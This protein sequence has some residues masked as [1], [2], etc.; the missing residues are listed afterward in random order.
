MDERA[1]QLTKL[2]DE[3]AARLAETALETEYVARLVDYLADEHGLEVPTEDARA[4]ERG[5]GIRAVSFERGTGV[6]G[7]PA[8]AVTVHVDDGAVVQAAAERRGPDVD[9]TVAMHF[10]TELAPD[11]EAAVRDLLEPRGQSVA[12]TVDETDD[13]ATYTI[14][15]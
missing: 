5:D 4:F 6:E 3:D 7:R 12:V 15:T 13:V 11:P 1:Q 10:P 14:E 8:T 9:G 2:D